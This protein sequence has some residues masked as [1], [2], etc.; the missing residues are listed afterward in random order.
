MEATIL[1]PTVASMP[2]APYNNR[3]MSPG[4]VL[5]NLCFLLFTANLI[6]FVDE[7]SVICILPVTLFAVAAIKALVATEAIAPFEITKFSSNAA[8]F[9]EIPL[10]TTSLG[11]S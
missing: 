2:S 7:F 8:S 10:I 1:F 5:L 6:S 3:K 4:L 11:T 9:P